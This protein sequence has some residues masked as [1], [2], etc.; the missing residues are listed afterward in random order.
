MELTKLIRG[1]CLRN[2]S[3]CITA[4]KPRCCYDNW[5]VMMTSLTNDS[6]KKMKNKKQWYIDYRV[7]RYILK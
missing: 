7:P 1:S 2:S 5:Y 6:N 4:H 3:F